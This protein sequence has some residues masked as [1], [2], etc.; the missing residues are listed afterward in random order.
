MQTMTVKDLMIP[1]SEYATVAK[2]ATL[3]E[4]V[5]ALEKAQ[6]RFCQT[7]YKHRAVLIVNGDEKVVGKVSQLDVIKGLEEGYKK[8]GDIS[9]VSHSGWSPELIKSMMNKYIF[10][11]MSQMRHRHD[12]GIEAVL[13]FV[14]EGSSFF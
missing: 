5:F 3:Y 8:I 2:E 7:R 1:L 12:E 6:E 13:K 14:P 10:S 11:E 4:T 9:A